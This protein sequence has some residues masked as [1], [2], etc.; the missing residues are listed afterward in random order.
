MDVAIINLATEHGMGKNRMSEHRDNHGFNHG[1]V[2]TSQI[3]S[4]DY[5]E[6]MNAMATKTAPGPSEATAAAADVDPVPQGEEPPARHEF[7]NLPIGPVLRHLRGNSLLRQVQK[8]TGISTQYISSIENGTN[9]PGMRVLQRLVCHYGTTIT[10]LLQHAER[11]RDNPEAF[12]DAGADGDF[13]QREDDELAETA[14]DYA[15]L[16]IGAVLRQLRGHMSLREVERHTGVAHHYLSPIEQGKRR[17]GAR[18]LQ[19]LAD[20]YGVSITEM[21][22][23]AAR[24]LED[25]ELGRDPDPSNDDVE[26][27]DNDKRRQLTER[28]AIGEILR[29]LRGEL[30]LRE[31]HQHTGIPVAVLSQFETGTRIPNVKVVQRLAVCYRVA[32]TDILKPTGILDDDH[33]DPDAERVNHLEHSYHYVLADPR[34]RTLPKPTDPVP[35]ETKRFLVNVYE[36]LTGKKL[37]Q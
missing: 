14:T 19:R 8:A 10:S 28:V 18:F 15:K 7:D 29:Q 21:L 12:D 30:T 22:R 25:E 36:R 17:P 31:V 2:I 23:R 24:L 6:D 1:T 3:E 33:L 4:D 35:P 20:F 27:A 37:L 16:P 26:D 32:M 5:N 34:F 11:L 9:R 13:P